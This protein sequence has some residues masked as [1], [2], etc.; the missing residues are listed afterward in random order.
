MGYLW[1]L[2]DCF[3]EIKLENKRLIIGGFN[4]LISDES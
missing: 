3:E 4:L 1:R 2:F